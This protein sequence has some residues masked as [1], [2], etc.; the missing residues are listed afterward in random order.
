MEYDLA[1]IIKLGNNNQYNSLC[2]IV[3]FMATPR[4]HGGSQARGQVGAT[5]TA[6]AI[7]AVTPD[8]SCI[9]G[10]HCSSQQHE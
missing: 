2:F 3:I 6:Y 4:A 5:T 9:C 7:A 1:R 8:L 10:L